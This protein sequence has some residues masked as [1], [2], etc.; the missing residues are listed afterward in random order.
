MTDVARAW[1][2]DGSDFTITDPPEPPETSTLPEGFG[3]GDYV[4]A[5]LL[6]WEGKTDDG[7]DVFELPATRTIVGNL[8]MTYSEELDSWRL[9]VNGQ[10]VDPSSLRHAPRPAAGVSL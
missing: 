5:R 2:N 9:S 7:E 4:E 3:D 10:S 6:G 1:Q 8:A